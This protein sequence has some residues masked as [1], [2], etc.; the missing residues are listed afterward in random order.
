MRIS[1][2]RSIGY[3]RL[4]SGGLPRQAGLAFCP[5]L[6][7]AD[8]LVSEGPARRGSSGRSGRGL[9][10]GMAALPEIMIMGDS[11]QE[12]GPAEAVVRYGVT[13]FNG[14]IVDEMFDARGGRLERFTGL[15]KDTAALNRRLSWP[16]AGRNIIGL[17]VEP[18]TA[19]LLQGNTA[20]RSAGSGPMSSPRA[21]AI[22][23]SLRT[24]SPQPTARSI[25]SRPAIYPSGG[26]LPGIAGRGP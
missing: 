8:E 12:D 9:G 18:H 10:G 1:S 24:S 3:G 11:G 15:L 4:D 17:A 16:A 13:L 20:R 21:T 6:S 19:L 22:A 5:P 2:P 23:P 26:R 25:W 7:A 14:A